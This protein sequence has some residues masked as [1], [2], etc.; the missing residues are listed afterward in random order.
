MIC[1]YKIVYLSFKGLY[2]HLSTRQIWQAQR[3]LSL[4][5]VSSLRP[6]ACLRPGPILAIGTVPS[7]ECEPDERLQRSVPELH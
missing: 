6:K 1:N 7:A 5:Q 3:A 2:W 4:K